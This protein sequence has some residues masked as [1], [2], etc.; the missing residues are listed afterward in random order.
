MV[1]NDLL[2]LNDILRLFKSKHSRKMQSILWSNIFFM[3]YKIKKYTRYYP[4]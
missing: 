2:Y 1:H 4:R 3:M